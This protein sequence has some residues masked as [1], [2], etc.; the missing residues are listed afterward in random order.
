MADPITPI[1]PITPVSPTPHTAPETALAMPPLQTDPEQHALPPRSQ[2]TRGRGAVMNPSNRF[3]SRSIE[4][5]PLANGSGDQQRPP[6]LYLEDSTRSIISTNQSPDIGFDKSLNPYRGCEHGCAYCYARPTHE[7]LGFS[8]GLEFETRILVKHRAPELLAE[9]FSTPGYEP[10]PLALSGVTDAYQPIERRLEI[11]RRC[12]M[13]L[14]EHRHPVLIVTK[15]RLVTRDLL[16]LKR[17]ARENAAAVFIS[18]TTLDPELSR[19]LEPRASSPTGRLAAMRELSAA[20]IPV[21]VMVAPVI[22]A[23]NDQEI[24]TLLRAA[25]DAGASTA[26]WVLLRLPYSLREQFEAWLRVHFPHRAERVLSRI[27]QLR[28]GQLNDPQFGSRMRGTGPWADH[29]SQLFETSCRRCGL[30]RDPVDLSSES[31]RRPG[32]VQLKLL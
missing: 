15:N 22:P 32:G 6:T 28:S 4:P 21:G 5:L 10:S 14:A 17:L 2:K 31:F 24:P 23:L 1:T 11:T 13:V 7:Y 9:A 12:L 16:L 20:G 19:T 3:E 8:P 30:D 27:G 18:L 25:A 29:L 26:R